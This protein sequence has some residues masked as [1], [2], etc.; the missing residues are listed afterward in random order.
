MRAWWR[1]VR[2]GRMTIGA[3]HVMTRAYLSGECMQMF[4]LG[5]R[6]VTW[7]SESRSPARK[8]HLHLV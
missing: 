8:R 2:R 7:A 6:S 1:D 4:D 3:V 5:R